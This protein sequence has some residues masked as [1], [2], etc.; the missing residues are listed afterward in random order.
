MIQ[1]P[2]LKLIIQG[3]TNCRIH[4]DRSTKLIGLALI[5]ENNN[6]CEKLSHWHFLPDEHHYV[7]YNWSQL[8]DHRDVTGTKTLFN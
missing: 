3:C 7:A 1:T 8:T 5:I 6:H 4:D 2:N